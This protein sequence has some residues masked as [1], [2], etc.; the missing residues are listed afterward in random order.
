[1]T[2]SGSSGVEF[3]GLRVVGEGG[4]EVAGVHARGGAV[5]VRGGV[6]RAEVDGLGEVGDGVGVPA[7][8]GERVAAVEVEFG[9]GG[10]E[11]DRAGERLGGPDVLAA[12]GVG[13]PAADERQ[14]IGNL[15][16]HEGDYKDRRSYFFPGRTLTLLDTSH[17]M[18]NAPARV[19]MTICDWLGTTALY[20]DPEI[21]N[22]SV[23]PG[24]RHDATR[25][26]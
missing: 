9:V 7:G 13:V 3:D 18:P 4:V 26:W 21:W 14:Y 6:V 15:L 24:L 8:G 17:S 1:M 10:V 5:V 2:G 23:S 20:S 22:D 11:V 25:T 12:P 16:G 19:V